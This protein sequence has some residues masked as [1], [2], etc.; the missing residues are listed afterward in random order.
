MNSRMWMNATTFAM[1]V[2]MSVGALAQS[3]PYGTPN[4]AAGTSTPGGS[5][6][7]MSPTSP[8]ATPPA[9]P[10]IASPNDVRNQPSAIGT[11]PAANAAIPNIGSPLPPGTIQSTPGGLTSQGRVGAGSSTCPCAMGAPSTPSQVAGCNC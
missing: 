8:S 2:G 1:A 7:S 5:V 10:G 6:P 3:T 9:T 11:S 4:A